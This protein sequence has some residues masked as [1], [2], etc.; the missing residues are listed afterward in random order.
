MPKVREAN[1]LIEQFTSED[2]NLE[3]IDVFTPMLDSDGKPRR[4]L[5]QADELHLSAA[6]YKLWAT[7]I[8]PHVH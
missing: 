8:G 6:G 7:I 1:N 2:G 4:E 5:F 3:F